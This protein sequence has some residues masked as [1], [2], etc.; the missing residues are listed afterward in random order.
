MEILNC[1]GLDRSQNSRPGKTQRA[2]P[3]TLTQQLMAELFQSSQQNISH[4]IQCIYKER[5]LS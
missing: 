3:A 5:E 1:Q 2:Q 4:R